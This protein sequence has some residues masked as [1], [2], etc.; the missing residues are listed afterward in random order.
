MKDSDKLVTET[1]ELIKISEI[2]IER[3]KKR[4][5]KTNEFINRKR[6]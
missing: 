1:K 6:K 5:E 3:N 2:I 4:I